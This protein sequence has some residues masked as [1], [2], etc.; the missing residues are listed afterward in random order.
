MAQLITDAVLIPDGMSEEPLHPIW[1]AFS[2]LLGKLPSIFA[3]YI[4]QDALEVQ[5]TPMAGFRASKIGSQTGMER[6]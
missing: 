3:R 2:G 6:S 5:Q 1:A 4:T